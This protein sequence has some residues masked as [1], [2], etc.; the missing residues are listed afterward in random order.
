MTTY[1]QTE[2]LF[3]NDTLG[4]QPCAWCGSESAVGVCPKSIAC[5]RCGAGPGSPCRR[6]SGHRAA[7]LHADRIRQ[8]EQGL[9]Q[10]RPDTQTAMG[11]VA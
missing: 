10:A 5:Q 3:T 1:E 8:A 6:P 7:E 2:P 11:L 9:E 4:G